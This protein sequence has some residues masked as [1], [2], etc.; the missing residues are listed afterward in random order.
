MPKKSNRDEF[1]NEMPP[2]YY[3]RVHGAKLA[4]EEWAKKIKCDPNIALAEEGK[5]QHLVG[6]RDEKLYQDILKHHP[7]TSAIIEYAEEH[8]I[9]HWQITDII[10]RMRADGIDVRKLDTI[11]MV[12]DLANKMKVNL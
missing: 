1:A 8:K 3:Y 6:P 7:V 4:K 12:E 5:V 9:M 2:E 10:K 11:S